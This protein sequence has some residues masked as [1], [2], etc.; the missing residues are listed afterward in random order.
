MVQIHFP[1]DLVMQ[2]QG[3]SPGSCWSPEDRGLGIC[4]IEIRTAIWNEL[5]LAQWCLKSLCLTPFLWLNQPGA[6]RLGLV[7]WSQVQMPQPERWEPQTQAEQKLRK[8][9]DQKWKR[10]KKRRQ[11]RR[12]EK[13][14]AR[15]S[16]EHD[17]SASAEQG[18]IAED[19]VLGPL[20]PT[21]GAAPSAVCQK[22]ETPEAEA[23]SHMPKQDAPKEDVAEAAS[24][25][26]MKEHVAKPVGV[27]RQQEQNVPMKSEVQSPTSPAEP[28]LMDACGDVP[29][30]SEKLETS[31]CTAQVDVKKEVAQM[32]PM[33]T[34]SEL[35][36]EYH[37]AF[38]ERGSPKPKRMVAQYR[39]SKR[40]ML[41]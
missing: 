34:D 20:A 1:R 40:K 33:K 8:L 18:A 37:R 24:A 36:D 27:A 4:Q 11:K 7:V 38:L 39:K 26:M 25:H 6:R 32:G 23:A 9:M 29:T 22:V 17:A 19:G 35:A 16:A 30:G 21:H 15:D 10:E 41:R 31:P 2:I 14:L 12:D 13:N 5:L 28:G 3:R